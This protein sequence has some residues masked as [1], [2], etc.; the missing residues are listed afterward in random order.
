MEVFV[1]SWN[2]QHQ[3][4][5]QFLFLATN[6]KILFGK[7]LTCTQSFASHI[8]A[9]AVS[10]LIDQKPGSMLSLYAAGGGFFLGG[11]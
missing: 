5:Y 4:Q 10:F 6:E 8:I 2:G 7:Y 9:T 11:G 1:P 3:H